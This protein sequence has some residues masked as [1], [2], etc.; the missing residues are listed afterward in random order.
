[1]IRIAISPEAFEA[2]DW[3]LP[4]AESAI[5]EAPTEGAFRAG[6]IDSVIWD[7]PCS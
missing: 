7:Q 4:L 6:S 2:T 1:M 3:T 5:P